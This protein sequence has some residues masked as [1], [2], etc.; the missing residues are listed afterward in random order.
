M[1]IPD[2]KQGGAAAGNGGQV[3]CVLILEADGHGSY[4]ARPAQSMADATAEELPAVLG[5]LNALL[6]PGTHPMVFSFFKAVSVLLVLSILFILFTVDVGDDVLIHLR[7]FLGLSVVLLVLTI[8]CGPLAPACAFYGA[9]HLRPACVRQVLW[10][11]PKGPGGGGGARRRDR[12][13]EKVQVKDL[14]PPPYSGASRGS[15]SRDTT[16]GS[17]VHVRAYSWNT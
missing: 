7:V 5:W 9:C 12:R 10:R 2:G 11:A 13:G 3:R 1:E 4:G 17:L 16:S 15:T 14:T 6:E 8:W